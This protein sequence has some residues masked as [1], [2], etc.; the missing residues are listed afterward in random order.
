MGTLKQKL[1]ARIQYLRKRQ[2]L[3]Q[4]CLAEKIGMDT[5]NL[6]NI[7]SGKRFM[8]AETLEKIAL[9]LHTTEK[10]LFNFSYKEPEKY[11]RTDIEELLDIASSDDLLFFIQTIK[12]YY[13]RIEKFK[14]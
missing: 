12:C 7:E 10:D 9:A 5:P 3:T 6:S 4:E 2:K 13:Q 11:L 8:T 1:G 14:Q